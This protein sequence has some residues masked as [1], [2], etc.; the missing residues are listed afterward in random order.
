MRIKA[1]E[2]E[3]TLVARLVAV[4]PVGRKREKGIEPGKTVAGD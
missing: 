1:R 3:H 2:P 4:K